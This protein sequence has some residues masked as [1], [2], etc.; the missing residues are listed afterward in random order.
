MCNFL[1]L[2]NFVS[3]GY[4]LLSF[5]LEVGPYKDKFNVTNK[6]SHN[7]EKDTNLLISELF[8]FKKPFLFRYLPENWYN[9]I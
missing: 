3:G 7:L 4:L 6:Y 2:D 8:I 9:L 5:K 1:S